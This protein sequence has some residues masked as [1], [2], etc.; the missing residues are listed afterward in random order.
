MG[1]GENISIIPAVGC[2]SSPVASQSLQ[3][4]VNDQ[5]THLARQITGNHERLLRIKD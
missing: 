5:L 2:M 3:L 4:R 1:N